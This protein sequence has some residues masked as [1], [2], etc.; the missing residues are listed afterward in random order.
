MVGN[1]TVMWR[2]KSAGDERGLGVT[3][4]TGQ[5]AVP[6]GMMAPITGEEGEVTVLAC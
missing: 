4:Y 3:Y 6:T 2:D 1:Q 5:I